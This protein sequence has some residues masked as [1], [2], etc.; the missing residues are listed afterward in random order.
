MDRPEVKGKPPLARVA[1]LL[2]GRGSN[3][4][5]LQRAMEAGD[6]PARTTLVVSD[7]PEA[8]GLEH[9]RRLGLAVASVPRSGEPNRLA[10][11]AKV[12]AEIE[13]AG[14]DWICLAGYMRL[15]SP[16]FI[17][18][19]PRRILNVHPSL[20]PAFP[21]LNA[22]QQAIQYGV[23]V[24][25]C[26]VH[27]VNEELDGG[28]IVVQKSVLVERGDTVETLS[29]RILA[30]EHR[31]YPEALRRLLTEPWSVSGRRLLFGP[32]EEA[33]RQSPREDGD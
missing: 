4:L 6:V 12:L 2:S 7:V 27:L 10:H 33:S 15:L 29:A 14:A 3:F 11:E 24:A 31:A 20:L 5:A 16:G 23:G 17:A 32:Q 28:P 30:E 18:R 26:T 8:A 19:F 22:Q 25:G 9:A 1:V 13:N 21:G